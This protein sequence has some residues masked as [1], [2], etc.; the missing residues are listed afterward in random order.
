MKGTTFLAC[1][2]VLAVAACPLAHPL[3]ST[4]CYPTSRYV[5][6]AGGLVRDALTELVWQQQASSTTMIWADAKTY[7]SSLGFRLPTIKELAS[8]VDLTVTSGATINQTAFPG[9]PATTFWTSSPY[10][11]SSGSVWIVDFSYGYSS[12]FNGGD[13]GY[14]G[15]GDDHSVRCVR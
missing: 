8:L 7:C 12:L 14:G 1:T 3:A 4:R 2:L 6:L 11:G 5:A 13:S 15:V 9:A 10:A